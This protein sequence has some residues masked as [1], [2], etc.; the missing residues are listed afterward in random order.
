MVGITGSSC[1]I[2]SFPDLKSTVAPTGTAAAA[3]S[4]CQYFHDDSEVPPGV[5]GKPTGACA[6]KEREDAEE[7]LLLATGNPARAVARPGTN[8][9]VR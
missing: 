6:E 4:F 5:V 1:S 2:P 8:P 3:N 7:E 9:F